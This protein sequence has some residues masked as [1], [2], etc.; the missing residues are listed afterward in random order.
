[1]A[2]AEAS[3]FTKRLDNGDYY[4]AVNR[5]KRNDGTGI[6]AHIVG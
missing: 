4:I 6:S 5:N 2:R 1:L 3:G